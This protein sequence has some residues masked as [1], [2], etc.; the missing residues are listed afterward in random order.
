M[1]W[2][3]ATNGCRLVLLIVFTTATILHGQQ[4]NRSH[5]F[6]PGSCGPVDP[7]YI[8]SA[9]DT[10]GIPFFFQRSEVAQATKFMLAETAQNHVT[11]LWAKGDLN[12]D[13][14]FLV[15]VDSTLEFVIFTI[16]V[17]DHNTK[18]EVFGPDT[19]PMASGLRAETTDFTCGRYIMLKKPV[20]GNYR[21]HI[22][23]SG[24][25]WLS[26]GG[27][28]EIFLYRVEF[29]EPGGRPGH[30]GMFAIRGQP[31]VSKPS[32]LE[33]NLSGDVLE[34]VFT[35]VT[36]ENRTIKMLN[37][38]PIRAE[39][40][41]HEFAGNFALPQQ[42]F[43]VL[44]SGVDQNGHPFQRV[45]EGLFRPTTISLALVSAPDLEPGNTV[46]VTFKATNTGHSDVFRLMAVCANGWPVGI[47]RNQI[48]LAGGESTNVVVSLT[49]PAQTPAYSAGDLV[50]TATSENDSSIMN[51]VVH[52]LSVEPR[53]K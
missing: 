40:D 32:N 52:H 19:V 6:A 34:V 2:F 9:E 44:A 37:L 49:V 46:T 23:G 39:R 20:P 18:M 35:L 4:P 15:P 22:T 1:D 27:R 16:S 43:R 14:E 7:A 29:V 53:R 24:R 28:S 47:D 26:V 13:R 21:V 10:G 30:E 3:R 42:P 33:A 41:E 8:R 50:L 12:G 38:Q 11:L 48:H 17:D 51:G 36:A 31:L 45:H 5:P 25:F